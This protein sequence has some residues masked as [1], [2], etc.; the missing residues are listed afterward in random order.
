[1]KYSDAAFEVEK[2]CR[3]WD[4]RGRAPRARARDAIAAARACVGVARAGDAVALAGITRAGVGVGLTRDRIS[5]T[6][7]RVTRTRAGII[8]TRVRTVL[9]RGGIAW[10]RGG[11]DWAWGKIIRARTI[12]ARPCAGS[13][14]TAPGSRRAWSFVGREGWSFIGHAC[15]MRER[16]FFPTL[17]RYGRGEDAIARACER[18][19]GCATR[20]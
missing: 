13:I 15:A 18:A 16:S 12:N 14:S 5:V 11:R 20:G 7:A 9:A 6:C 19:S 1:M 8:L 2:V 17:R 10:A 3:R 4:A